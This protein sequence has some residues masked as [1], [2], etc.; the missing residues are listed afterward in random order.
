MRI[1]LDHNATTPVRDEVAQAMLRA[2]RDGFGNPSSVHAEGAAA[3]AA[4]ERARE[5][6]AALVGAQPGEVVF[7]S[8]ATEANH[9]ALRG[10]LG[11]A[12]AGAR[13]VTTCAEHPSV[14]EPAA[15]LEAAGHPVTRLPVDPDGRLGEGALAAALAEPAALVSVLLANNETGVLQDGAA[16]GAACA[17]RG[18]PLHLDAT[19]A[20]GKWPVDV[21]ALGASLL[22]GSAH[23]LGGP[24]GA[25]FLVCA[26][27]VALAPW[28]RGG[29][30]ERGRRGGTEN[31]PGA[32]GL[33]AA[34]ELAARELEARVREWGRLRDRL[35]EGIREKIPDVRR[36]GC[37]RQVLPNTLSVEFRGADGEALLQALDLEG[38]AVSTGAACHSGSLEP[39]PVLRAM[40]RSEAEARAS[41]R[42]SLGH[43]IG[44]AEIERVLALLPDLVARA[45]EALA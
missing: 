38:V 44:D 32:V 19:Q 12:G 4:L 9:A 39:S 45:R 13:L 27:G 36:N 34:C 42:F 15:A 33:G 40:G 41:L 17:E 16:L 28:L 30:Q 11:A 18:V 5:Q 3:R 24:K 35:W 31:V 6:V 7:T 29:P 8:G 21:R 25:G 23:K 22:S 20:V 14:A 26:R 43:G 37:A 1:Y 2:L 10:V